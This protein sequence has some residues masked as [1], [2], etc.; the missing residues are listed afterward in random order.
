MNFFYCCLIPCCFMVDI[1]RNGTQR[2][3]ARKDIDQE[4]R[5]KKKEGGG[6]EDKTDHALS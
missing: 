2:M 3:E 6:G 5:G 1:V 4:K